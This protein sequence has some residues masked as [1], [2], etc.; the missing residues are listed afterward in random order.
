[1]FRLSRR[2]AKTTIW[3][4]KFISRKNTDNAMAKQKIKSTDTQ[5]IKQQYTDTQH[6][7]Q[8]YTDTQHIK[9]YIKTKYH[10]Q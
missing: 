10:E 1:M 8:Q 7:E 3:T 5:H 2:E 6:I 9:Q 4:I